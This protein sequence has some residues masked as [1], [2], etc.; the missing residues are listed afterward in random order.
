VPHGSRYSYQEHRAAPLHE[1]TDPTLTSA[2]GGAAAIGRRTTS[3]LLDVVS[4]TV[5]A[6]V[7]RGFPDRAL[8]VR[9]LLQVEAVPRPLWRFQGAP[10]R[11]RDMVIVTDL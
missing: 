2:L 7:R 1:I 8:T 10:P 9:R 5:C 4:P 6:G 11:A 3:V